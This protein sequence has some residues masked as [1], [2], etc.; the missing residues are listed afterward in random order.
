[1]GVIKW[2]CDVPNGTTQGYFCKLYNV[3]AFNNLN[4]FMIVSN[5]LKISCI[6]IL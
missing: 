5:P 4:A 3:L 2:T 6:N 1:M